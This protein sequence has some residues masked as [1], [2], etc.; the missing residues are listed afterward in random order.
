METIGREIYRSI[1]QGKWLYISYTNRSELTTKYWIAILDIDVNDQTFSVDAFNVVKGLDVIPIKKIHFSSIKSAKVIEGSFYSIN[2]V[3]KKRIDAFPE[4]F[5]FIF[6][7]NPNFNI[8]DYLVEC[9]RLDTPPYKTNYKMITGIDDDVLVVNDEY[10]L[11]ASQFEDLVGHLHY[12]ILEDR[13]KITQELCMNVIS[14]QTDKG[15]YV[16]AHKK[17]FLDVKSKTLRAEKEIQINREFTIDGTTQSIRQ[18]LP[19]EDLD[20]LDDVQ[21]DRERILDE[22]AHYSHFVKTVT[23]S[24]FIICLEADIN[25]DLNDQYD[26]IRAMFD[27]G[28]SDAVTVPI[29]AFFGNLK[30]LPRRIKEYP[31]ILL[32]KGINLDQLVAIDNAMRYPVTYVQGP[33]GTG[34]T[35]TILNT[36]ITGFFNEKTILV[37][38][39]N[40]HPM[41]GV[42]KKI[43]KLEYKG[44]KIPFPAIRLGNNEVTLTALAEIKYLYL[45][46]KGT[47]IAEDSLTKKKKR[48]ELQV[49]SLSLLLTKYEHKL[50]LLERK[51]TLRKLISDEPSLSLSI[52]IQTKQ[53]KEVDDELAS[54]GN[55][56]DED[57]L[58]F[59]ETNN[60]D[61]ITYLNF[62]SAMYI[63]RLGEPKYEPLLNILEIENDDEKV[64]AFNHYLA[65]EENLRRF[66]R[67]FPIIITTN[68]SA[69]HLG[70]PRPYFD[71][72][73]MD[74]AS[75][76]DLA[77]G[78]I[79]IIRGENLLL[80]GDPQQLNPVISLDPKVN[81]RLM[82]RYRV[83]SEYDYVA[84]SVYKTFI[85]A[86]SIS[87][88]ILLSCHYRC[89][90][91]I[92]DFNNR[93]YYNNKLQIKTP[94][95]DNAP[96]PL[97]YIDCPISVTDGKNTSMGE[98]QEIIN[99]VKT[100]SNEN[101]GIIT[102]FV[103]QKESINF[104]LQENNIDNVTCGTVHAFQ[105][106][107]KNV[108]LFSTALTDETSPK[109][110]EWLKNN[111]ELINVAVSR[112][113]Q[114]LVVLSNNKVLD[115]LANKKEKDDLCELCEY[116]RSNGVSKVSSNCTETRALGFKPWSTE[117]ET[118]FFENLGQALNICNQSCVL[119]KEVA[120]SQVFDDG[121][122]I[123]DLFFTGRFDFVV[124]KTLPLTKKPIAMFAIELN[125]KEH[126]DDPKVQARDKKKQEICAKKHFLLINVEN[127]Y[128][129]RYNHIKEIL[130]NYFKSERS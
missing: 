88:E 68:L 54:I 29:K 3:L 106:D 38:S 30:T 22:I 79:P 127:V 43:R 33:P 50:D 110:Y 113:A 20:L 24:P 40:N 61:F 25:I 111:K 64:A 48:K 83:S 27:A 31:I 49:E 55:I 129:R 59:T 107:E 16:L 44:S 75:Q 94:I 58:A 76:C 47:V 36:I 72:T 99:Y 51:E 81:A 39:Y 12:S 105:G 89:H 11:S 53:L 9:N 6:H 126:H 71:L 4:E 124:Y 95:K 13:K 100:H 130:E 21:A 42:Y 66:M 77:T 123:N 101:I 19:E 78:L 35:T 10:P 23:D 15:L 46:T 60:E 102:P 125:G 82:T 17:L 67:V 26:G 116:V 2:E 96:S 63:Q 32:D 5:S 118:T 37:S 119:H 70:L 8:L 84:N 18:F 109:T 28:N 115:I 117:T 114:S 97:V 7:D 121:E 112:A 41:D 69:F 104:A 103:R 122:P 85:A 1:M 80:V 93:K 73:I 52:E 92:I 57:A 90:K 86:D 108:I 65:D 14:I 56:T 120:I 34:K 98:V 45:Q 87:E 62:T 91:K 74:E 128:A